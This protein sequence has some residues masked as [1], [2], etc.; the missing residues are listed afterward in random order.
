MFRL[1]GKIINKNKIQKS[2]VFESHQIISKDEL[3][4]I[5]LEEI[6]YHFNLSVPMWLE[7]N[8]KH[9]AKFSSTK[10]YRDHFI[11]EISFDCLEI[12]IIEMDKDKN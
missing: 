12:E 8:T 5:G 4:K 3:T 9:M 10:F 2:F 6:C 7:D 11:E 1:W